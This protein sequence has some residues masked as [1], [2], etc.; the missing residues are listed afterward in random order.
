MSSNS[1]YLA[2]LIDAPLQS[3]G[4]SSRFQRRTTGLHPTKSGVVGMVCA[5]MGLAKGSAAE[6]ETLPKLASL[7]MSC[8]TLPK[9]MGGRWQGS[10]E[11]LR[12]GRLEDYNTVLGT[13]R[14]D[15][16]ISN[17]AVETRR[18]YL[19]DARFGV[20]LGGDRAILD[21]VAG[22]MQDPV[23]GVWFGRK[24]CI[25][26]DVVVRGVFGSVEEARRILIGDEPAGCFTCVD[27][28]DRFE[29][30]TDTLNDQPVS[31]GDAT[32]SG[33]D[34]RRFAPRRIEVR[35]GS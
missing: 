7:R 23:W 3:W 10:P 18:Q 21:R 13:R 2:L 35:P 32:S 24:C 25:P 27:E 11:E 29:D 22:A 8:L 20:I 6:R 33:L 1:A 9:R 5:A 16:A 34:A 19:L 4:C 26:A 15:G 17:N 28:V 31:F 30:G 14:A 12:M